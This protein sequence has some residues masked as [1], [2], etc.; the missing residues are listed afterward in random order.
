MPMVKILE[1]RG[2]LCLIVLVGLAFVGGVAAQAVFAFLFSAL[3][4]NH[5]RFERSAEAALYFGLIGLVTAL[6]FGLIAGI[7][8]LWRRQ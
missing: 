6:A 7:P 3:M 5:G 2:R 1:S 4:G 8:F